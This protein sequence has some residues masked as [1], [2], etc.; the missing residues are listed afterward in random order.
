MYISLL[1]SS[2]ERQ[3]DGYKCCAPMELQ[4][5]VVKIESK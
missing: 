5:R 1:P 2:D 3:I 4:N